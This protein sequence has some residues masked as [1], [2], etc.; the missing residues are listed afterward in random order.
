M[1]GILIF[2]QVRSLCN[3]LEPYYNLFWDFSYGMEKKEEIKRKRKIKIPQNVAYLSCSA[4][5][6]HFARIK[7]QKDI[8]KIQEGILR[9]NV[10]EIV[11]T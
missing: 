3:S 5:R 2:L 8:L 9:K 10:R 1:F 11:A 6:T 7:I 4:G